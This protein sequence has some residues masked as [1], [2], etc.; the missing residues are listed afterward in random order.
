MKNLNQVLQDKRILSSSIQ[1]FKVAIYS[2]TLAA[3]ETK[4]ATWRLLDT[5]RLNTD[6]TLCQ[7]LSSRQHQAER[8]LK[9][10]PD[11]KEMPLIVKTTAKLH[12]PM[13]SN[14]KE[15][16]KNSSSHSMIKNK[17]KAKYSM[18][19]GDRQLLN[20]EEST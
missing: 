1:I 7:M 6:R 3:R 13:K 14:K 2:T 5:L 19:K 12:L 16:N 11:F 9:E 10:Q 15:V 8:L 4:A 17:M 18:N 20:H